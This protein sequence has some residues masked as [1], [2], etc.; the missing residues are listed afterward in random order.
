MQDTAEDH[1]WK[2][3]DPDLIWV[4]DKLIVSRKLDI[5]VARSDLMFRIRAFIL[6]VLVLIC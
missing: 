6:C 5:T 2:T 3:I 1:V 4:M